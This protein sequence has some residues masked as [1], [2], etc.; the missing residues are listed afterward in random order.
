MLPFKSSRKLYGLLRV[1]GSVT[2]DVVMA[3]S[4]G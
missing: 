1:G 2:A 4:F 3:Y